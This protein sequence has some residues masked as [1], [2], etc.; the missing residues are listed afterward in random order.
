MPMARNVLLITSDQQHW[1]TLG[2]VAPGLRTPHLDRLAAGGL[3][4][5]RAYCPNPTCTPSRAS[6]ITGL[7]PSQHGA[8]SLGTRLD[9]AVPTLGTRLHSAGLRTAL[10]GKAHFQPLASHPRWPSIEAYP[11]L[12]DYSHWRSFRGPWYGF[13]HVELLRNHGDEGH[14]GMHYGLWLEERC[15]G[16]R[17]WFRQPGGSAAGGHRG[18][19]ELPEDLHYNRWIEQRTIAWLEAAKEDAQ[20]FFAWASFPDPHPPYVTSGRWATLYQPGEIEIPDGGD[21][22]ITRWPPYLARTR[23]ERPSYGDCEEPE[24]HALHGCRSHRHDRSALAED[25]AVYHGMT[26][27][28]DDCAGGILNALDRLGLS[29]ETLV[30]FTTDHGHYFGQHGLIAKGP[31]HFEDMVRVPFIARLPGVI[32]GG[33]ASDALLSLVDFAPTVLSALGLEGGRTMCGVDQM[34][35]WTGT[36]DSV[37]D[38]VLVENRHQPH[39]LHLDTYIDRR[40]KLTVQRGQA[41]GELYDLERD[42]GEHRN[43][44]ED[45]QAQEAKG[46]VLLRM[47]QAQ[48]AK[49][50]VPMPRLAGS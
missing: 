33:K 45:P 14:V 31:F 27:F 17:K 29:G 11:T 4:V 10:I 42:P 23:E 43:L 44:W 5:D 22:D 40:W 16:W 24:G 50:P 3:R 13:D 46:R 47:V 34:P 32:A 12:Q 48:M 20:P 6:L 49:A 21:D 38:H 8:Y 28:V 41:W 15:P 18:A 19:W 9:P 26:A 30:V 36:M 7:M 2:C 1:R 37:R 35:V 25:I 39:R